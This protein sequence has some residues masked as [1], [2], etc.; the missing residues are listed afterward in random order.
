MRIREV[1]IT[2]HDL[3]A[4]AA[5]Y[6]DQLQMPV[7][8]EADRVTVTIGSGRLVLAHR[9]RFNAS[10]TWPSVSHPTTFPSP[11]HLPGHG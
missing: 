4:S 11:G 10:T 5:F 6:R 8:V 2:T 7:D 1:A 9:E 3:D